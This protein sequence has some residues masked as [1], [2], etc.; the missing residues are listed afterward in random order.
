MRVGIAGLGKTRSILT[1][2]N[3]PMLPINHTPPNLD[4]TTSQHR[5]PFAVAP[6]KIQER[7]SAAWFLSP[8]YGELLKLFLKSI[9]YDRARIRERKRKQ[10]IYAIPKERRPSFQPPFRRAQRPHCINRWFMQKHQM[11]AYHREHSG[12]PINQ[13]NVPD[14][15]D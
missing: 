9:E 1:M 11:L 15:R 7:R 13:A 10:L 12:V 3:R 5:R 4:R 6:A 8:L 2:L 14:A